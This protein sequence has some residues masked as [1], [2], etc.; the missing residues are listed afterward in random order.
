M[1]YCDDSESVISWGSEEII[2]P[3][4][5]PIDN[6]MHRYFVDFIVETKQHDGSKAIQLI[7]IKPKKQCKPP[8]TPVR[9]TRRYIS[10]VRTWGVNSAKWKAAT[11]YASGRGWIFKILN[12]DHLLI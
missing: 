7:E 12:E 2:V 9:K 6:K 1:C 4:K 5:S 11:E 10:E 3:Y 8:K